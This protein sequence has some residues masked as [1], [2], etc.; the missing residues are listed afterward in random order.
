[1]GWVDEGGDGELK[2]G[3]GEYMKDVREDYDAC[4]VINDCKKMLGM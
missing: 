3:G 2:K 1:M 4:I